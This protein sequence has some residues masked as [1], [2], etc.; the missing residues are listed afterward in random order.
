MWPTNGCEC[1]LSTEP[2]D[3]VHCLI[4]E[5]AVSTAGILGRAVLQDQASDEHKDQLLAHA[6]E[7]SCTRGRYLSLIY[8]LFDISVS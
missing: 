4:G 2:V 6:L 7:I 3:S 1:D 5:A 8:K